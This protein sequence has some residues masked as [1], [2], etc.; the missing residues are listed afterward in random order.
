[1]PGSWEINKLDPGEKDSGE[2]SWALWAGQVVIWMQ[3]TP[4][5]LVIAGGGDLPVSIE[6]G[7]RCPGA[8][9]HLRAWGL[10]GMS[11]D[12]RCGGVLS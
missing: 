6:P 7:L 12:S 10:K 4:E 8:L 2:E 3:W 11:A 1:M 9:R 5:G